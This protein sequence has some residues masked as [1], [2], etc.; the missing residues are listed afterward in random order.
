MQIRS[1][2]LASFNTLRDIALGAFDLPLRLPG[3]YFDKET[4]LHYNYYRDYDPSSGIYKQSDPIGLDGGLNTYAYVLGNPLAKMD[5]LGLVASDS[6]QVALGRI[7]RDPVEAAR[8]AGQAAGIVC[9]SSIPCD[10]GHQLQ[11][12]INARCL[13]LLSQIEGRAGAPVAYEA[14]LETCRTEFNKRCRTSMACS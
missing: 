14:C 8:K 3:Q 13:P 9:A 10:A 1:R 5:P 4:N 11:N 2:Y 6:T 12:L 7:F